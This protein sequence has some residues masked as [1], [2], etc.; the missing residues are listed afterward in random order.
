MDL[1]GTIKRTPNLIPRTKRIKATLSCDINEVKVNYIF[2]DFVS[3]CMYLEGV[4]S[5]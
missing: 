4:A 3:K 1:F 2:F 5:Q